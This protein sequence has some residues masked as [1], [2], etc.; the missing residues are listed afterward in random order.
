[1]LGP[2]KAEKLLQRMMELSAATN[3]REISHLLPRAFR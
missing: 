2:K 1:M 3:L